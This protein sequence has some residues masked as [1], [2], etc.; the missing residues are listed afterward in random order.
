MP[1]PRRTLP[2]SPLD[3][4]LRSSSPDVR[5]TPSSSARPSSDGIPRSIESPHHPAAPPPANSLTT[6]LATTQLA[7]GSREH[8]RPSIDAD[9]AQTMQFAAGVTKPMAANR[10]DGSFGDQ[11][12]KFVEDASTRL[13]AKPSPAGVAGGVMRPN[14]RVVFPAM[15]AV[16]L[17]NGTT[18]PLT[19]APRFPL[20]SDPSSA[21]AL[22]S[23]S[24]ARTL[25]A[26]QPI[27]AAA[28]PAFPLPP[29][30][31][32]RPG[33]RATSPSAPLSL[34]DEKARIAAPL[35]DSSAAVQ[36]A[37]QAALD[38][39]RAFIAESFR[40]ARVSGLGAPEE[41][42]MRVQP[43]TT[44]GVAAR[45]Q[46]H[47]YDREV[48]TAVLYMLLAVLTCVLAPVAW[49]H[50]EEQLLRSHALVFRIERAVG[51]AL[52]LAAV[53]VIACGITVLLVR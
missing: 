29:T 20:M 34:R 22:A 39:R 6:S 50:A 44:V 30:Q 31:F 17:A 16:Q 53:A 2:L 48:R 25:F 12:E 24:S 40:D 9:A 27:L 51:L 36:R 18:P 42:T 49:I 4:C 41:P 5:P 43:L 7:R 47:A 52:T 19:G 14:A 8:A 13:V 37:V 23:N 46:L 35:R 1:D 26:P 3:S 32:E 28:R 15:P 21:R 33:L 11:R 45:E 10:L 38:K